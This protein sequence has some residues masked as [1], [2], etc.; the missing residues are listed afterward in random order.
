MHCVRGLCLKT[1]ISKSILLGET[2]GSLWILSRHSQSSSDPSTGEFFTLFSLFPSRRC[3]LGR[4]RARRASAALVPLLGFLGCVVQK[5]RIVRILKSGREGRVCCSS[6]AGRGAGR[7][8]WGSASSVSSSLLLTELHEA[9]S[10][11]AAFKSLLREP[12]R[13]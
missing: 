13:G 6:G 9:C 5:S 1:F 7:C 2:S 3:C 11:G 4:A 12:L 10:S 8:A